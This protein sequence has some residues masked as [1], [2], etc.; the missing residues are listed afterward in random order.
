MARGPVLLQL[1][2]IQAAIREGRVHPYT[3]EA[4]SMEVTKGLKAATMKLH[5][6]KNLLRLS[7][8]LSGLVP[9]LNLAYYVRSADR[10]LAMSYPILIIQ[11]QNK[12]IRLAATG[13]ANFGTISN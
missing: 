10:P 1:L 8:E 12:L 5:R 6:M 9:H 2:A 4:S 7:S 13:L 11:H 3:I